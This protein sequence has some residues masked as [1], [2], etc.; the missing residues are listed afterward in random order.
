LY[1]Q[2]DGQVMKLL[3]GTALYTGGD[4]VF[5][6]LTCEKARD[7]SPASRRRSTLVAYMVPTLEQCEV[8]MPGV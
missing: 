8:P 3:A 5:V 7:D 6:C 4:R 1:K 2:A